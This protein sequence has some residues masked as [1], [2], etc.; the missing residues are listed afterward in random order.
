MHGDQN[1]S[2]LYFALI[3]LG[4]I[5]GNA[6]PDKRARDPTDRSADSPTAQC[7]HDRA[8][9]DN[10]AYARKCQSANASQPAEGPSDYS[11]RADSAHRAFW[12]L[13]VVLM[14][15]VSCTTVVGKEHR[16]VIIRKTPHLELIHD[17]IGLGL[18]VGDTKYCI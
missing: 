11:A 2:L 18:S 6:H 7:G 1:I 8:S 12:G 3:A 13:G 10:R 9:G 15:E 5:F 4:F 14:R 16:N 17:G